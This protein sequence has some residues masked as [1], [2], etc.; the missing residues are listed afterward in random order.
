MKIK[1]VYSVLVLFV[2]AATCS[3]QT[4]IDSVLTSVSRSNKKILAS[5]KLLESVILES[6][7]GLYPANPYVEYDYLNGGPSTPGEQH[8][9][10]IMQSFD[11]PSVYS[12]KN[13]LAKE[14]A[15]SA[16][17][18]FNIV[19]QN[20]LLEAKLVCVD[21]VYH[22][23]VQS[24]LLQRMKATE[25]ISE[26]FRTKMEKGDGTI[27]DVNKARI[28]LVEIRK[29][30]LRNQ[31][32][33]TQLEDV[34]LT[35]NGGDAIIF[36]DSDYFPEPE[37]GPFE[38]LEN[39]Y[40]ANDPVRKLLAQEHS[41]AQKQL[42]LNKAMRFPKFELGYRYQD[43]PGQQFNGIHSGISI[44]LWENRN[45][46][47]AQRSKVLFAELEVQD[48]RIEHYYEIKKA[49]SD[50]QTQGVLLKEYQAIFSEQKNIELLEKAL[51][52][53]EISTI[54]YFLESS[55]FYNAFDNYLMTERDYY[56]S[57]SELFKYKL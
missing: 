21:L 26:A 35:L 27:L 51:R 25:K 32:A 16:E 8:E 37:I 20:I 38:K 13:Q 22:R 18:Q 31:T 45:R 24:E 14:K 54:E 52:L 55:Y 19:R 30:L 41:A 4:S 57:I 29:D 12:R 42:E 33:I 40:E 9:L 23:K 43:F 6:R 11:F 28:L 44:P 34:L 53:G 7:V 56:R 36:N 46:V 10:L 50:W 48:H 49:Y 2:Y 47:K 17:H 5:E 15:L 3:A 39:D 1:F